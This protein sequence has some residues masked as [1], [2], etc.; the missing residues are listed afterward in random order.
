MTT[1]RLTST[2]GLLAVACAG[3]MGAAGPAQAQVQLS[4][5]ALPLA[6]AQ[7]AAS[8]AIAHCESLGHRVSTSVVD[9]SGVERVF[10]RGDHST[11][12]TH[13]TAFDKAYTVATLGPVF[14]ATSTSALVEKIGKSPTG[15]ALSG[16]RHVILLA[17]GVAIRAG[18]ETIAALGVGGAPGGAIDEQCARAGVERIQQRVD[19]LQAGAR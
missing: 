2:V 6:L 11:V 5:R 8:Q 16:I 7:E 15:P 12:H 9:T 17:G 10:L 14:G 3:A 18:D 1:N 13:D 4:G 19:A